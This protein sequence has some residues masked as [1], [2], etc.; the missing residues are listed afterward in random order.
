MKFFATVLAIVILTG[1]VFSQDH[2]VQESSQRGFSESKVHKS[3]APSWNDFD[4]SSGKMLFNAGSDFVGTTIAYMRKGN[5]RMLYGFNVDILSISSPVANSSNNL[6]VSPL[7]QSSLVVP[8]LFT[9]K[10][11]FINNPYS[12]LSPYAITG[13]GPT[14]GFRLNPSTNFFNSLSNIQTQLGAGGYIGTG[15][16]LLWM[17]DWAFSADIRY[18]VMYFNNSIGFNN[19]YNGVSFGIGFMRAFGL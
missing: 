2:P 3:Y 5:S 8:L 16:D 4:E 7:T 13:V 12:K 6:F 1:A 10:F 18:N 9:M 11:R 14:L 19:Q 15:V 17:E